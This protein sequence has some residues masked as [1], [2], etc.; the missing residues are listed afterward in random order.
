MKK[1]IKLDYWVNYEGVFNQQSFRLVAY[2]GLMFWDNNCVEYSDED[3]KGRISFNNLDQALNHA[4]RWKK[5]AKVIKK[6]NVF[7]EGFEDGASDEVHK[8]RTE[9]RKV[10]L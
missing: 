2:D 10:Q 7:F 1:K 9:E 6:E 3:Y 8:E 4:R 5:N